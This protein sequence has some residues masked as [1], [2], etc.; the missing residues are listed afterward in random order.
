[1]NK[2]SNNFGASSWAD[3]DADDHSSFH[4]YVLQHCTHAQEAPASQ[5]RQDDN[6]SGSRGR[7]NSGEYQER[8]PRRNS[9]E[10][11]RREKLPVPD[12]PPFKCYVGNIPFQTTEN[13]LAD[14]FQGL[15][16]VDV[17]IPN[18]FQ[19]GRS[20]GFAYVEFGDRDS[21]EQALTADGDMFRS[22]PLRIDVAGERKPRDS[23]KRGYQRNNDRY[24]QRDGGDR[25]GGDRYGQR[26]GGDRYGQRD[27]G[28]R[29]GRRDNDR[30]G[31]TNSRESTEDAPRERSKISLLPRTKS[32]EDK[33]ANQRAN[34][35]GEAKPRDENAYLERKK[36]KELEKV[37][38][39]KEKPRDDDVRGPRGGKGGR[40]DNK[41]SAPSRSDGAWTRGG[42][43]QSA[44][45]AP[46]SKPKNLKKSDSK[47]EAKAP[48]AKP[49]VAATKMTNAFTLLNDDS[50]SD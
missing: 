26:D 50:D 21:I 12:H 27:G 43:V 3:E 11:E 2:F 4:S 38:V 34:I 16:V 35:F 40:G 18:D 47:K 17:Q 25:Y 15:N 33:D 5:P 30:Y 24:G 36:V 46:S 45:S 32:N 13:D 42:S 14:Y 8:R 49:A 44:A 9:G 23:S 19:T 48:V 41:S 1:M 10:Y 20:K 39:E 22:R 7:A 29:Y 6:E 28:D 31:R 37:K